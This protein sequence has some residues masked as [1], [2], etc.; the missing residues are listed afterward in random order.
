VDH[1]YVN[2]RVEECVY[3]KVVRIL[4]RNERKQ[5]RYERKYDGKE[6][7]LTFHAG[8]NLGYWEGRVSALE[9]VLDLLEDKGMK[10]EADFGKIIADM[11][12]NLRLEDS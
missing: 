9:E 2:Q 8:W 1:D 10:P 7:T 11:G 3:E 6:G 4:Q 5:E 12:R